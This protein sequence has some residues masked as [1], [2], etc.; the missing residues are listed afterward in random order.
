VYQ[1]ENQALADGLHD[2]TCRYVRRALL[3]QGRGRVEAYSSEAHTQWTY[4]GPPLPSWGLRHVRSQPAK[5]ALSIKKAGEPR[6][7]ASKSPHIRVW[8]WGTDSAACRKSG[9]DTNGIKL[10]VTPCICGS[11]E[12]HRHHGHGEE[13]TGCQRRSHLRIPRP[14]PGWRRPR[15]I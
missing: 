10:S 11:C 5:Q 3:P 9:T 8:K 12:E 13:L 1:R 2:Y 7:I 4:V 6:A 15:G 14:Q